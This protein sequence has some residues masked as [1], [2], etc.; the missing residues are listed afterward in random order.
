MEFGCGLWRPD[1]SARP[2]KPWPAPGYCLAALCA[3]S[4]RLFAYKDLY[5]LKVT[6]ISASVHEKLRS[7]AANAET[8]FRGTELCSGTLPEPGIA[9]GVHH[10]RIHH[11][12]H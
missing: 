3:P 4:C 8:K 1:K 10:H 2:G 7:S 12:L 11:H 5:D 9:P 6:G